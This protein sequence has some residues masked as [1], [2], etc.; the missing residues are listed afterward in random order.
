MGWVGGLVYGKRGRS[1]AGQ[2]CAASACECARMYG[3]SEM[4]E[5]GTKRIGKVSRSLGNWRQNQA[6]AQWEWMKEKG[7]S[8]LSDGPSPGTMRGR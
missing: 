8:G 6:S 3:N 7:K 1:N 4:G 2:L 5:E